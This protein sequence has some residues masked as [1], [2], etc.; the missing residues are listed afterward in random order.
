MA[1]IEDFN[2]A[3]PERPDASPSHRHGRAVRDRRPVC[4]LATALQI[5]GSPAVEAR[6]ASAVGS[7][8]GPPLRVSCCVGSPAALA[9]DDRSSIREPYGRDAS[10]PGGTDRGEATILTETWGRLAGR[11][12]PGS[13]RTRKWAARTRSGPAVA[14]SLS[15]ARQDGRSRWS[16]RCGVR[17]VPPARGADCGLTSSTANPRGSTGTFRTGSSAGHPPGL[18]HLTRTLVGRGGG[19]AECGA[20]ACGARRPRQ[21]AGSVACRCRDGRVSFAAVGREPGAGGS[22]RAAVHRR[23]DRRWARTGSRA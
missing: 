10:G 17:L 5:Y 14:G 12:A 23:L 6:V 20:E 2:S 19:N 7:Q 18:P 4:W 15:G 21:R 13:R 11:R 22:E 9:P 1:P 16:S 3:Q 8:E